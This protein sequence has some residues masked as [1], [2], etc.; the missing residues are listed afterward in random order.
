MLDD[1]GIRDDTVF[2]RI[3]GESRQK[4]QA[5]DMA[6]AVMKRAAEDFHLL[7]GGD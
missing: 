5:D 3:R 4:D 2:D 6:D 7:D 1:E